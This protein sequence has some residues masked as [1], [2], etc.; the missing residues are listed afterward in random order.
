M[1]DVFIS[2]V[3]VLNIDV[4]YFVKRPAQII[5]IIIKNHLHLYHTFIITDCFFFLVLI[6]ITIT[7]IVTKNPPLAFSKLKPHIWYVSHNVDTKVKLWF[8]SNVGLNF[9]FVTKKLIYIVLIISCIKKET[10]LQQ[11]GKLLRDAW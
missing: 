8:H 5:Y 10:K 2:N 3:H 4:L 9:I 1:K 6:I 11:K 7:F